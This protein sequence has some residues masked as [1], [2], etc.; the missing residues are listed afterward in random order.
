MYSPLFILKC[1]YIILLFHTDSIFTISSFAHTCNLPCV[2]SVLSHCV[3]PLDSPVN[4]LT[5]TQCFHLR[6]WVS[7]DICQHQL[8]RSNSSCIENESNSDF[9]ATLHSQ[10]GWNKSKCK[11]HSC[12]VLCSHLFWSAVSEQSGVEP[13]LGLC[14][15]PP[16]RWRHFN[17]SPHPPCH[18]RFH[19]LFVWSVTPGCCH[20]GWSS[21]W[22]AF[23]DTHDV[24]S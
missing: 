2:Y 3:S 14:L 15:T 4:I 18:F 12:S 9:A 5:C 7:L 10:W 16:G 8:T 13:R 21:G 6:W 24:F 17:L 11:I 20:A 23:H 22:V 19:P 1:N